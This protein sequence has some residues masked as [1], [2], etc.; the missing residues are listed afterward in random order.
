M[1][2]NIRSTVFVGGFGGQFEDLDNHTLVFVDV[3]KDLLVIWNLTHMA[4]KYEYRQTKSKVQ[5]GEW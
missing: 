3:H 5:K 1:K 4:K 2:G